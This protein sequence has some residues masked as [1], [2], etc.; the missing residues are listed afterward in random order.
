RLIFQAAPDSERAA[1]VSHAIDMLRLGELQRQ[2]IW[3]ATEST[4]IAGAMICLQVP[5]ASALVWPPQAEPGAQRTAIEDALVMHCNGW[6]R[7][8]GVRVAQCLMEEKDQL[9]AV[10]LLRNEFRKVTSL[11]YLRHDLT[12]VPAMPIDSLRYQT[13]RDADPAL[14]RAT[15]ERTYQETLDCPELNG[16]R[17]M[18]EIVAGHVAQGRHDPNR[19]WLAFE[20]DLPVAV[21]LLTA[22]PE[23]WAW[24]LSYLGVVPT[25]RRQGFARNLAYKAI[26]EARRAGQSKL[27]L[28]VDRRNLPARVLYESLGFVLYD[29]REVYLALWPK[30]K[31]LPAVP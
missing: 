4:L 23:W 1:R 26:G 25:A 2:G 9:L 30:D 21:L 18:E 7:G 15:L 3:V 5:G 29:H 16:V 10:P 24:D 31:M 6:L 11:E 28:S 19:W 22:T 13:Y 14:F 17:A 20:G 12:R 8:Q 27:T